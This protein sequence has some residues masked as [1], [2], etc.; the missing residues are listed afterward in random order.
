MASFK[1]HF[2]VLNHTGPGDGQMSFLFQANLEGNDFAK[3]PLEVAYSSELT[4]K[5]MG[6]GGGLLHSHVQTYPIGSNQQQ[7]TCYHYKDDNEFTILPRWDEPPYNPNDAMRFLENGDVIRLNHVPT[8]CNLHSHTVLAPIEVVDYI[9]RGTNIN[10]I[11]S[12]TTR[13]RIKHEAL[14]CYLRAANASSQPSFLLAVPAG[15]HKLYN[16]PFLR[17]SWHLNVAMMTSNN[18]LVPDPD[19]EDIFA[20]KPFDW[21]EWDHFLYVGQIAFY[22]WALH[23]VPFLIMG[24]VTYL[25]HYLPTLYFSVLMLSHVLDHF[26]FS[27]KRYTKKTT[28]IVF[29]VLACIIIFTF[30]WFKGVVFGITGPIA[31][32]KGLRWR[33]PQVVAVVAVEEEV[34]EE[35]EEAQTLSLN[36]TDMPVFSLPK[37]KIYT[38]FNGVAGEGLRL[39]ELKLIIDE[40]SL[41]IEASQNGR[42]C[43]RKRK[44]ARRG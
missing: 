38:L 9:N 29:G 18:A 27:S 11:H 33:K 34:V 15:D 12:L 26:I 31:E 35:P 7:V 22:G 42:P 10:Q 28:N 36:L 8:T 43:I 23:F 5:N 25:H 30:W 3:N 20:S 32:H 40:E 41:L 2:L 21:P 39:N 44:V 24:R 16:S 13:L 19:K 1:I 6:C 4:L 14:G 17:D 37:A